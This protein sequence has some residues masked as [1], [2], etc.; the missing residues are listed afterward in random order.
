MH[1]MFINNKEFQYLITP[2]HAKQIYSQIHTNVQEKNRPN[3]Q[4]DHTINLQAYQ[5]NEFAEKSIPKID[6]YSRKKWSAP[7]EKTERKKKQ[8]LL[9]IETGSIYDFLFLVIRWPSL[10]HYRDHLG[11]NLLHIAGKQ[12]QAEIYS[13][14]I[15]KLGVQALKHKNNVS[16]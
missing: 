5:F 7:D 3:C 14:L 9:S 11:N 15:S 4:F 8:L 13:I 10:L 2:G 12:N 6:R 16:I 1:R